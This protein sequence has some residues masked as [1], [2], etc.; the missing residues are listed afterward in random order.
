V[1]GIKP[2]GVNEKLGGTAIK[3]WHMQAGSVSLIKKDVEWHRYEYR[4]KVESTLKLECGAAKA[5]FGTSSEI[6]ENTHYNPGG[7]VIIAL[8][9]WVH[10]IVDTGGDPTG[11]GPWNYIMYDGEDGKITTVISAY[12]VGNQHQQGALTASQ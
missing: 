8:G 12:R 6:F 4:E 9:P 3:I 2:F 11:C 5:E 1:N 7:T 10:K